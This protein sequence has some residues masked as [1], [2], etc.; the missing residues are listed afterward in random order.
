MFNATNQL[1]LSWSRRPRVSSLANTSLKCKPECCH[2]QF[3]GIV[4]I[5]LLSYLYVFSPPLLFEL[6]FVLLWSTSSST[7]STA[8]AESERIPSSFACLLL[9]TLSK[10]CSCLCLLR[11]NN[12]RWNE[13][14]NSMCLNKKVA[15][16]VPKSQGCCCC[17][18]FLSHHPKAQILGKLFMKWDE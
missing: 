16:T 7:T 15:L 10:C 4:W 6:F 14:R 11:S 5:F 2:V 18:S 12:R 13:L 1:I 9:E 17:C 3:S 8:S